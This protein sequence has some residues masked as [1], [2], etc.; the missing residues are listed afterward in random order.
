MIKVLAGLGCALALLALVEGA[1]RLA[2]P[3]SWLQFDHEREDGFLVFIDRDNGYRFHDAFFARPNF[4]QVRGGLRYRTNSVG[5]RESRQIPRRS[6]PGT[7]RILAIGD[8]W[9]YGL[10]QPQGQTIADHL[11]RLLPAR[12]GVA[13]VEVINAGVPGSSAFDML[14]RWRS[15]A[16]N[17]EVHGVLL[18]TSH[19]LN[20]QQKTLAARRRWYA[21]ARGA[22]YV[23]LRLYLGLR[24]LLV[25]L[26]RR[27]G[28]RP[29]QGAG[30]SDV[31]DMQ[32]LVS[33]ARHRGLK[34]WMMLAPSWHEREELTRP[35]LNAV[36]AAYVK[37]LGPLGVRFGGHALRQRSCYG[38]HDKTHPGPAG[39]RVMAEV[40]AEI[41]VSGASR[42]VQVERPPCRKE[43]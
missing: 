1:L 9:I 8:S 33:D 41:I 5:F 19:N 21:S 30:H 28:A 26:T 11:E 36:N 10:A 16:E 23:D 4:D 37:A 17:Y 7:H 15:L 38:S 39:A 25:P 6:P 42:P 34:V 22:P 14:R 31:R 13:R 29:G 18:S 43:R 20:R 35:E 32:A 27:A 24:R 3:L 40:M 12:L 2:L